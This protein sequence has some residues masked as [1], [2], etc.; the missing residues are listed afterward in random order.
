[1]AI[2]WTGL[3]KQ[4]LKAVAAR[5]RPDTNASGPMVE[6][7]KADMRT[8]V[9]IHHRKHHN[10]WLTVVDDSGPMISCVCRGG[11]GVNVQPENVMKRRQV[12]KPIPMSR[13]RAGGATCGDENLFGL[14]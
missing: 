11:Y 14:K 7:V 4:G 9:D 10:D 6:Q 3:L 13:P 5:Q 2:D 8:I 1:M 12:A